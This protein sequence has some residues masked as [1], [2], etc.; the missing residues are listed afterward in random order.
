[1]VELFANDPIISGFSD[2]PLNSVLKPN[3]KIVKNTLL[4]NTMN[5]II[6]R[7]ATACCIIY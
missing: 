5:T 2:D 4:D 3:R 6:I 1:M 7:P